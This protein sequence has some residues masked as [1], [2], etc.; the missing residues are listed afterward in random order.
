[1]RQQIKLTDVVLS[2]RMREDYGDLTGLKDSI[3]RHG[4]IQPVVIDDKNNLIAGGRRYRSHQE[5]GLEFIDFTY[6]SQVDED[7]RAELEFEEN[8]Y[9]KSMTWQEEC[10][11]ILDIY[12]KKKRKG[13]LEGFTQNW[14]LTIAEMFKMAIGTANYILI[15][16]KKLRSEKALPE[17]KRRYWKFNSVNEAY[18][19]GILADKQDEINKEL[20]RRAQVATQTPTTTQAH[21]RKL[22]TEV[23][24]ITANPD[25]LAA[26]RKR[27][28][29]NP[30][31]IVPFETYWEER[32]GAVEDIKNTVYLSNNLI[33][34]DS[35]LFMNDPDNAGR[36]DHII[37]DIPY[38]ID[39]TNMEQQGGMTD[40]DRIASNHGVEDN[41][42]LFRDF[43]PAA[44]KCTK[45]RS[46]VVT[47]CDPLL[48]EYMHDLAVEAGF[49]VQRWPYIWRKINQSV[50]NNC[51]GY[52]TTKDYE[53][54]LVCRKPS[55]T[56]FEKRNTSFTDASNNEV[57]KLTGHPFAKPFELTRDLCH[58]VSMEGQSILEPFAG[59]GSMVIQMLRMNR[60][61]VAVEEK[62]IHYN[63]LLENVKN[64]YYLKL[65]P[66]FNFK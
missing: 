59:G 56:L 51:A 32:K 2:P 38:A 49:A 6:Y 4:L 65:N 44:W 1:M 23:A 26:E 3:T 18:R 11:G 15:V 53:T 22:I 16:A 13:A 33:Q 12:E 40:I 63:S 7:T 66:N 42:K 46:F 64:H 20:A 29:G 21:E 9:R 31:N 30:L 48:F 43:F 5:L 24:Q 27:Y 28:E 35:I 50:G 54:V 10:L 61:V 39:V 19:L 52:N 17:D 62:E 41:L 58:M 14:Q 34:G 25:L 60:H 37:T 57:T 8:F 45:E 47:C 36:F 55:T